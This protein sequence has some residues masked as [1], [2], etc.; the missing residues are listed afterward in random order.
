MIM[1]EIE[2]IYNYIDSHFNEHVEKLRDYLRQESVSLVEGHN[3]NVDKCARYL[4]DM[5]E[6]IGGKT[7]LVQFEKGYPVVFGRLMSKRKDAKTLIFYSLYDAMP[8]EEPEWKADPFAAEILDA[9]EIGLPKEYGKC[10]V[11]RCARNQKGPTMGFINALEA[12]LKVTGDIPVNVLFNIEGEEELGSPHMAPF[13][14]QYVKE[15]KEAD[16]VWYGNPAINEKG[17]HIIYACGTRGLI[18]LI[19]KVR[20]G[21]WGGPEQRALFA[22]E[23]AWV[24]EPIW[25]LIKALDSLKDLDGRVLIDGFYENVQPPTA[26]EEDFIRKAAAAIDEE[27]LKKRLGIKRFRGGKSAKE[28]LPKYIT[29]PLLNIDGIQGGYTGY[30]IKTN[31]PNSAFAKMHIRLVPNM[32]PDE[33]LK[34]LRSHL[35]RNGFSHVEIETL[36]QYNWA[37]TSTTAGMIKA[38]AKAAERHGYQSVVWPRYYACAPFYVYTEPPLNLP[39]VS[40]GLSYMGNLHEANEFMTV[41][42]LRLYEKYTTTFLYEFAK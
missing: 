18:A 12:I 23:A 37:Y 30:H 20:G 7:E 42:G 5:I 4:C 35:D 6:S 14:D 39:V 40:H 17:Y 25:H 15:L 16:G 22:P 3:D 32:K 10:I 13:R 26:E 36:I 41:E 9:E 8:A 38:A 2:K 11:A 34:K 28:L 29:E 1:S 24:D 27:G 19:L 33:I 31:L 21:D